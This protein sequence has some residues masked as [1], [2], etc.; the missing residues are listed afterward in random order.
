MCQDVVSF[1][2]Q[3]D[4]SDAAAEELLGSMQDTGIFRFGQ[5]DPLLIRSGTGYER[6]LE[7]Q[8]RNDV[9]ALFH[10]GAQDICVATG[11]RHFR[12]GVMNNDRGQRLQIARAA[13]SA[14]SASF[15]N[16]DSGEW[17]VFLGDDIGRKGTD[18]EHLCG[19]S[20]SARNTRITEVAKLAM[21]RP[22]RAT[23]P[24]L[25]GSP[26]ITPRIKMASKSSA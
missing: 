24:G 5:N 19:G 7:V 17:G 1:A 14:P 11:Q 10:R 20:A 9:R 25:I 4:L 26:S 6:G 3:R 23:C 18:G 2:E 22:L 8:W 15:T 16:D 12:I 13:V 21:A